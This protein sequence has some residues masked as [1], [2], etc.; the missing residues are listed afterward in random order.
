LNKNGVDTCQI[1]GVCSEPEAL[2]PSL[3]L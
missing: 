1:S 2:E 3:G